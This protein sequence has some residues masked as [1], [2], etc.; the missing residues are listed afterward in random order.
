VRSFTPRDA[1]ACKRLYLEGPIGHENASND[2]G[3]D[4]DDIPLAYF[5]SPA[6]HFWVAENDQDEVVGMIG[7]QAH[8]FGEGEIR[9]LRVRCDHRGRGI[10]SALLETAIKF[11]KEHEH[12]KVTLDTAFDPEPTIKMFEKLQ[13]KHART[14]DLGGKT[15]FYFYL[16]LYW[17]HQPRRHDKK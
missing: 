16:D 11:C 13:F 9:R 7:V 2:T 1:Q 10:G 6:S 12:L 4:I 15:L 14:K 5:G 3:I 8:E 17:G